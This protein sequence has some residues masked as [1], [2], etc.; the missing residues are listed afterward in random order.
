MDWFLT[1]PN[2]GKIVDNVL[3]QRHGNRSY[4]FEME[5][6]ENA[7]VFCSIPKRTVFYLRGMCKDSYLKHEYIALMENGNMKFYS[8]DG[9]ISIR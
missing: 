5:T 9:H 2:G 6:D 1:N 4:L 7:C 3:I 8:L